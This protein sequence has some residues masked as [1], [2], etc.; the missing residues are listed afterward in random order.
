MFE[1]LLQVEQ[2][3]TE[4]DD[5]KALELLKEI[6]KGEKLTVEDKIVCTLLDSHINFSLGK[7]EQAIEEVEKVWSNIRKMENPILILYYSNIK[8]NAFWTLGKFDEGIKFFEE[9]LDVI[10][11]LQHKVPKNK[12]T[13]FK[14]K[15]SDFLRN[16]GILFWFKG[17]LDTSLE[18]HKQ[19]LALGKEINNKSSISSSYNN[20]G[21]VYWSKSEIDEAIEYYKR[22]LSIS[23]ELGMNQRI[24]SIL[25]N[26]GNVY[27]SKGELDKALENQQRSLEINK[28][29]GYKRSSAI[30]HINVGVIFQ[31]KGELDYALDY[32]EKG[33][34]LSEEIEYK[35]NI[36][37]AL[38]N[39]GNIFD[40]K[41]N[42]DLA[43][44]YYERSLKLYKELGIKEK[45]ALILANIGS[46]C[47]LKGN[48][49]EAFE[50]FKRSLIIYEE[51]GNSLG[52]AL[53]LFQLVI[54]AIDQNNQELTQE[55]L[56][57]LQ[58][59]NKAVKIR[60]VDQRYRLAQALSLKSSEQPRNKTKAIVLF[61]QI[62]EEE[63]VDHSLT[64]KALIHLC[65]ML[66]Q[67]LKQTAEIELLGEIKDLV[68]KLQEIAKEQSSDSILAEIYRLEALL[69][70]AELNLKETGQLFQK[71][72]ALAEEKGLENIALNIR[73][74]Q[75]RLE[76][77]IKL[78]EELQEREAPLEETLQYVKIEESMKQLQQEETVTY[79]KLFSLKI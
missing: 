36:A 32:Y 67:E 63:I 69:A 39:I 50:Y 15:K 49:K 79:R 75:N 72:L 25:S 8:S 64:V 27:T 38:N 23:E 43:I 7:R 71:G 31:L 70:L 59:I 9:H 73:E 10:T 66:T 11:K 45:T 1:E 57:K 34:Q 17:E 68:H 47:K 16:G 56:E 58:Q 29:F 6:S 37:L 12:A 5:N 76:Q 65:D 53:V 30:S 51:L 42:P 13:F 41:G 61:E 26:L 3:M 24:A 14:K 2:L 60:S 40:L 46:N 54:E 19:G 44:E 48:F 74:E 77:H 28:K 4:G 21:L 35:S 78:W 33:L 52:S 22:A 62:I 55:Y 20:I 18:Y